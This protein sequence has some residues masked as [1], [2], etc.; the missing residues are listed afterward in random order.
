MTNLNLSHIN[1][2][3]IVNKTDPYQMEL[4]NSNIHIFTIRETLLKTDDDLTMKMGPH[5]T[6]KYTIHQGQLAN[7]GVNWPWSRKTYK[8]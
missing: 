6:M 5:H 1:A 8:C 7:R 3:S 2:H 4:T